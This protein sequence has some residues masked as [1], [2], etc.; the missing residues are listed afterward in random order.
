MGTRLGPRLG[1]SSGDLG[2][3]LR[4]GTYPATPASTQRINSSSWSVVPTATTL[5]PGALDTMACTIPLSG[6]ME[7]STRTT[8]GRAA[9]MDLQAVRA[10]GPCA[11]DFEG[12]IQGEGLRPGFRRA[13]EYGREP[14]RESCPGSSRG[15]ARCGRHGWGGVHRPIRFPA[16]S[17]PQGRAPWG[18]QDPP[19]IRSHP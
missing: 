14:T 7:P 6:M 19:W 10:G 4:R 12:F 1:S 2:A 16:C 18:E 15:R 5:T 17:N 11:D 8:A 3:W 13:R 9:A